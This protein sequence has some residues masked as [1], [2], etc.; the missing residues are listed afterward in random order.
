VNANMSVSTGPKASR[1]RLA[2]VQGGGDSSISCAT[3][4]RLVAA[5]RRSSTSSTRRATSVA[6]VRRW[7]WELER[8]SGCTGVRLGGR[9]E[10]G[11]RRRPKK[12]TTGSYF[13]EVKGGLK[14]TLGSW[15]TKAG[16]SHDIGFNAGSAVQI[17]GTAKIKGSDVT[18][19]AESK[20]TIK[21]S[22]ITIEMTPSAV[23]ITG[24]FDGS[25]ASVDQGDEQY[26]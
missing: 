13:L 2:E 21:A 9:R 19:A 12:I 11:A 3:L 26:V 4:S 6:P 17:A 25:I 20:L 10:R 8:A 18:I 7:W 5:Q 1:S 22:G 14:L 15:T 23:N 16:A 24:R